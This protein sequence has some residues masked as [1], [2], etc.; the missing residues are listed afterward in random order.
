MVYRGA[1]AT[2]L[3]DELQKTVRSVQNRER[4]ATHVLATL[5]WAEVS[6]PDD[7]LFSN[8]IFAVIGAFDVDKVREELVINVP[9]IPTLEV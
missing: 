6:F 5:A 4:V 7:Q 3:V 8:K 1:S 2:A 9:W